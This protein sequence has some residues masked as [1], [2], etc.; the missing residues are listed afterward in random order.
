VTECLGLADYLLIAEA[1]GSTNLSAPEVAIA[2]P[3][4]DKSA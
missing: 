1:A 3:G 2:T 4:A